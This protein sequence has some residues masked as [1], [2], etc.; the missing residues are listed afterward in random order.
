M[1]AIELVNN[2]TVSVEELLD[3]VNGDN[4]EHVQESLNKATGFKKTTLDFN[5]DEDWDT[6][7][8]LNA[9]LVE[10]AF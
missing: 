7:T 1:K 9:E 8:M 10:S 4:W 6:E 2:G 3:F 5:T